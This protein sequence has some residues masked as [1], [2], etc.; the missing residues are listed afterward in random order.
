MPPPDLPTVD[1]FDWDELEGARG[2]GAPPRPHGAAPV[3][4]AAPPLPRAEPLARTPSGQLAIPRDRPSNL[5]VSASAKWKA[6][7]SEAPG[8]FN[9]ASELL[10]APE[11][12]LLERVT[13]PATPLALDEPATP[14]EIEGT[15]LVVDPDGQA[16]R[17]V[18]V[19]VSAQHIPTLKVVT[20]MDASSAL[21]ILAERPVHLVLAE[22][23]LPDGSGMVL[24]SQLD[25]EKRLDG[26][27][28]VI[29]SS[30][31][32]VESKILALRGGVTDYLVKPMD[33]AELGA[34]CVSMLTRARAQRARLRKR[35]YMLAGDFSALS[36]PDLL[37]MLELSRVTGT[38]SVMTRQTNA[39]VLIADGKARHAAYG[40]IVGDDAVYRLMADGSGR[41]E[42]TPGRCDVTD[43]EATVTQSITSL[44]ME[45][46]RLLDEGEIERAPASR[47]VGAARSTFP[48]L[49]P[50][51]SASLSKGSAARF[52]QRGY[53]AGALHVLDSRGL[54]AFTTEEP[55]GERVHVLLVAD[56]AEAA[57]VM[58]RGAAPV[59][60]VAM[61]AALTQ[62]AK[63]LGLSF[64]FEG[65]DR[66][67]VVLLDAR[68]PAAF[69]P[70][71][72]RAPTVVVL[73]PPGGDLLSLGLSARNDLD[74]LL[75]GLS[76]L[77]LVGLGSDRL[78]QLVRDL[79]VLQRGGTIVA[80]MGGRL[81]EV[82]LA[83]LIVRGLV[84]FAAS[85]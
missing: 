61:L 27:P 71:L 79:A 36:F 83:D 58:T 77:A 46:A 23:D 75:L 56:P 7:Q 64:D 84:A 8:R 54:G 72:L 74:A 37:V 55:S 32:R 60:D 65:G 1:D 4:P 34:R 47:T 41:F 62:E 81:G 29:F 5:L 24:F 53:T 76:P 38:L 49:S 73:A 25:H 42:F 82:A 12:A 16:R 50:L 52:S 22:A 45:G 80:T 33:Q 17:A 31:D 43:E 85:G 11:L 13:A 57:G 69:A 66:L 6:R 14:E 59:S 2:A 67:D 44:V 10:D 70:S 9:L 15:I 30:D 35:A 26:I 78:P 63:T 40:T 20:A 21:A 3:V 48:S 51:V 28:F 68:A 39:T 19:A 18:E